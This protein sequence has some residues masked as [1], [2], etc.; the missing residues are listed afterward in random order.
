V[1]YFKLGL[2]LGGLLAGI[3]FGADAALKVFAHIENKTAGT[4]A[5]A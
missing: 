3:H 1:R 5:A 4:T 2:M